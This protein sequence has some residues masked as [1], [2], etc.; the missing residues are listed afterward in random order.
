M[1]QLTDIEKVD[2]KK[3]EDEILKLFV[4][5]NEDDNEDE[6]LDST[7]G[8]NYLELTEDEI[9]LIHNIFYGIVI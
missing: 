9:Q 5:E 3:E 6:I 8:K 1:K 2:K 7:I 4:E